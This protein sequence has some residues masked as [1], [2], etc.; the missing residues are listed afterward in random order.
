MIPESPPQVQ[1][2]VISVTGKKTSRVISGP[3]LLGLASIVLLSNCSM[4]NRLTDHSKGDRAFIAYWPPPEGDK[5]LTLAVKDNIDMKGLVTSAGSEHLLKNN[6]PARKDAA[7][8]AIARQRGVLIVGK[9]NLSEF[10]VAPSGIN[11]FFGTPENPRDGW[12][13]YLPGGSSS[14]SAVAVASGRADVAFGTDTAGSVRVPAACCGVVGLKTT[15]GLIST[16]GVH[17]IEPKHLDTV[18]PLGK[19]IART[20]QGMDLLQSGFFSRY[21]SATAAKPTGAH[22]R[23]G[24]LVVPGTD[25]EIDRAIDAAL[26]AAGFKVVR[27][28][29]NFRA[30]WEMAKDDGN[31]VA[32]AG[33][34]ISD[35]QFQG[36]FG[37]STR[38]KSALLAGQIAYNTNYQAAL[39]RQR[40]WKRTLERVFTKVDFIALPTIQTKVPVIPPDLKIGLVEA[41]I[42]NMQNTV[43]ANYGGIPALAMPVPLDD[44]DREVTSLQLMGPP[45]SEA[46]LLNA[47][48]LVEAAVKR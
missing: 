35:K 15:F 31:T 36:E 16:E 4:V 2:E 21:A 44:S 32:A 11:E 47:G 8:L 14:G 34:W 39:S 27:L 18:G 20:V 38:T 43:P 9:A 13:K 45:R 46:E 5:R 1:P 23:I 19:D 48:R 26:V 29:D 10:A 7:C 30:K 40:A 42:L 33:A 37:I 28:D 24:R 22:I 3:L 6:R 25:P 17:P 12:R 41:V